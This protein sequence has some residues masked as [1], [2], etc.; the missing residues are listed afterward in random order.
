LHWEGGGRAGVGGGEV[1]VI[2]HDAFFRETK[3]KNLEKFT[4][5]ADGTLDRFESL[6]KNRI[7]KLVRFE[8]QVS[9]DPNLKVSYD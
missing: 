3:G 6:R 8:L 1:V 4:H 2:G 7:Y 9:K 5:W